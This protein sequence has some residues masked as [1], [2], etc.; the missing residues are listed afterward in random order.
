M[1][2][3]PSQISFLENEDGTWTESSSESLK[4]LLDTH[5]S[6][7]TESEGLEE[8]GQPENLMMNHDGE[9]LAEVIVAKSRIIKALSRFEPFKSPGLDGIFPAQL[10]QLKDEI[11]DWLCVIF[12][13]TIRLN[14]IPIHSKSRQGI[15]HEAERLQTYQSL[16]LS[17]ENLRETY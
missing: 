2:K 7:S 6:G 16:L 8:N 12:K 4:L 17:I 10:Q 15:S 11:L 1:P 14:Y 9:A 13:A 3:T 5:L